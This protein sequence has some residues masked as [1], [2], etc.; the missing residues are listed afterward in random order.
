MRATA[1][2]QRVAI[3]W[4]HAT[5]VGVACL[6]ALLV[7]ELGFRLVNGAP[8]RSR[9]FE[10]YY[11]SGD[12]YGS[13]TVNG[14]LESPEGPERYGYSRHFGVFLS[15]VGAS[16]P[17][18]V[19]RR[20][21]FLFNH[22]LS[23]YAATDIDRI[24]REQ[25]GSIRVF[26]IGGSVAVGSSASSK[27]K[28]WHALL[29]KRLQREFHRE[30]IYVFNG[31][32]GA[33]VSTQERLAFDLAVAPRKP[34][35]VIDLNGANDVAAVLHGGAAPGDPIQ[36]GAYYE[37]F[38]D[39][40]L[41]RWLFEN[42]AIANYAITR[43][44]DRLQARHLADLV[45]QPEKGRQAVDA[46]VGVYTENMRYILERCR[47]DRVE[48]L[49]VLQPHEV[50]SRQRS[51][52]APNRTDTD[53]WSAAYAGILRGFASEQAERRVADMSNLMNGD[54]LGW[55]A[56]MVHPNDDGQLAVADFVFD[57]AKDAVTAAIAR[58]RALVRALASPP[59]AGIIRSP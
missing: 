7:A 51:G 8:H 18:S 4:L 13:Q 30:D 37:Y 44:I 56:D 17:R 53:L 32:M 15:E 45:A 31:A 10:P 3:A 33:F 59:P 50:L 54:H 42:S 27:D 49:V 14:L 38:Y 41:I 16:M 12:F 58:K 24:A 26:V 48:A 36:T 39:T 35:V 25:P 57:Y 21:D 34:D 29:E 19:L 2:L 52:L 11:L 40:S 46:I 5:L 22:Y 20:S 55:Y 28:V 9:P 47:A 43:H 6:C 23:R 1:R